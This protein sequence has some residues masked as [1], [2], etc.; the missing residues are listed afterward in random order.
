M[1][2]MIGGTLLACV[3]AIFLIE[4][5]RAPLKGVASTMSRLADGDLSVDIDGSERRDEVG[6]MVRATIVFRDA[7][8]ENLRLEEEAAAARRLAGEEASRRSSEM[9][10]NERQLKQAISALSVV[11]QFL[12]KGDLEKGMDSNLASDFIEM[13]T[14][15]NDAVEALRSTISDVRE[16]TD[17]M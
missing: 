11:L 12:S 4:P 2:V 3:G 7:A 6:D 1:A 10:R 9:D 17:E 13:A 5:L 16:A 14:T 8:R 15:Y